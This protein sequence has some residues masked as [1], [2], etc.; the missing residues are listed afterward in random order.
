M[1]QTLFAFDV[2][3]FPFQRGTRLRLATF[4]GHA[5]AGPERVLLRG[6]DGSPDSASVAYYGT[7][8]RVGDELWMWYLGNAD[9]GTPRQRLLHARSRD[10]RTWTKPRLGLVE[11][12]GS[13][14]NN[15]CDL[16]VDGHLQAAVVFY[17]PNDPDPAR[18]FKLSF[19]SEVFDK[20]MAVAF[21][22]DGLRWQLHPDNP[23]GPYF[24]EQSGGTRF[25]GRY[26][27]NG[28]GATGHWA[29]AGSARRLVTHESH[30]FE[31]WSPVGSLGFTRDLQP[32]RPTIYGG[33]AGP[34]VHLGAS[35]WNR[36]N[37]LVGFYGMWDGPV[38]ND[39]R[40][41]SMDIGLITSRDGLQ[42]H[43]PIPDMPIIAARETKALDVHGYFPAIMQGQGF[44]NV[45]DETL[46]WYSPWPETDADAILLASW[47][48]DRLGWLQPFTA[49]FSATVI[50]EPLDLAAHALAFNIE[51]L[52][53]YAWI[54]VELLGEDFRPL[55]GFS[56]ADAV[57]LS[58]S[59]FDVPVAW[60]SHPAGAE[61]VR[62]QIT[63]R[64]VRPE[65]ARLYA[66]EIG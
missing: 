62:L 36:G 34:Q 38:S 28:Q 60:L 2:A 4:P 43:E 42:F 26:L 5:D 16:D 66:V 55:A 35:L 27:V 63:F 65:D 57:V 45:G 53:D 32:P 12:D 10:G 22:S 59:G 24:F 30:D 52:S 9:Q 21:S 25:Q 64:G 33:V 44:E 6:P 1:S 13:S 46:V 41:V 58:E 56:G 23:V 40:V 8:A 54:D 61:R 3:A 15:I 20:R 47:P 48:R 31:H 17:E 19:E 29:A 51:L 37:V 18:R 11:F 39:R 50:S 14:E 49:D 7:V